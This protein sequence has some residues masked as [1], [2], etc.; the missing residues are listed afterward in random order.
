[1]GPFGSATL[2]VGALLSGFVAPFTGRQV[3]ADSVG[4]ATLEAEHVSAATCKSE[5]IVVY[6]S[7]SSSASA[8]SCSQEAR[9][10]DETSRS[11]AYLIATATPGY[12]M[13]RQGLERAIAR[14]HPAFVN[15]LAAAIA[16]ARRAG[17][18]LVGLFSAY[19][20]PAFGVGG[21][22]DKF[23]SRHTYG[24]AVDIVGIGAPGTPNALLWHEI[25]ARHGVICP[26]GPHNAVEWNHCQ[27]TWAKI[28]LPDSPLRETV[29]AEG[30]INLEG[31]FEVGDSIIAA[32]GTAERSTA[33]P[34]PHF[35]K[36]RRARTAMPVERR[37]TAAV[38][39][40]Q[41][42]SAASWAVLL[43]GDRSEIN[44]LAAYHRLSKRHA[45]I[46]GAYQP[47][48]VRTS[49]GVNT[50]AVW[51]RVRIEAN[52]RPAAESLCSRLRTVGGSCLVQR[53]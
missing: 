50:A 42:R 47:V 36:P 3:L 28:I 1:M 11:R 17:L 2:M 20:P 16:E 12:T 4:P 27:P 45:A 41:P 14:L 13:M 30:T 39:S 29:T 32:S 18:P 38:T 24:L 21:F 31:M 44:A 9:E 49:P 8:S 51:H 23:R 19:R 53:I 52:S 33:D 35:F 46:L 34:P 10:L 48:L 40:T 37:I 15:R 6:M 7:Q 5:D 25:A 43:V 22:V 26:Y